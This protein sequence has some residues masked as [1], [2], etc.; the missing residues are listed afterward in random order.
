[1]GYLYSVPIEISKTTILRAAAYKLGFSPSNIDTQTYVFVDD[2][3]T[4]PANPVGFPAEWAGNPA[5]YEM[6]PEVIGETDLFNGT[7][8]ESIKDDLKS[9]PVMSVVMA[10]EDLFGN[11]GIYDHPQ[12][13]G[14]IWE[15]PAS[16]ELFYPDSRKTDL[17][18]DCGIRSMEGPVEAQTFPS[19]DFA[20]VFER[21]TEL[22]S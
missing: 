8:R 18:I 3:V 1:M 12:G 19:M 9:L 14:T 5:D 17:Q 21:S 2:V 6:D 20:S 13:E 15:K 10:P 16:I 7:Y 22:G 11:S 4:Q